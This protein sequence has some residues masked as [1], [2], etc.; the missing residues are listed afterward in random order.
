MSTYLERAQPRARDRTMFLWSS[1]LASADK[2]EGVGNDFGRRIANNRGRRQNRFT[3]LTPNP[4]RYICKSNK[5]EKA[6]YT[7]E[8]AYSVVV[9]L[10]CICFFRHQRQRKCIF[11]LEKV[12]LTEYCLIYHKAE[13]ISQDDIIYSAIETKIPKDK[14]F[15]ISF[16]SRVGCFGVFEQFKREQR[17]INCI[18]V[19]VYK[20]L[21]MHVVISRGLQAGFK[22]A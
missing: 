20:R 7:Y 5:K 22:E 19:H 6:G 2:E 16:I 8:R 3:I 10:T 1:I 13:K 12:R 11:V 14:T 21:L 9:F 17:C 15:F 4:G 18:I